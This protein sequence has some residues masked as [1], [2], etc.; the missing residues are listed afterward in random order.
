MNPIIRFVNWY[1]EHLDKSQ[2]ITLAILLSQVPH[3]VWGG[4]VLL[5]SG[6]VANVNPVLDF[7]L[8][9]VDLFEIPLIIKVLFD[10]LVLR[11]KRKIEAKTKQDNLK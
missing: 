7:F 4:D 9:G 3:F 11:R 5:G 8:Y 6:M 10:T 1:A 2:W